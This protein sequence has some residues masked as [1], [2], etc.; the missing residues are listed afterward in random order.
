MPEIFLNKKKVKVIQYGEHCDQSI[1][2]MKFCSEMMY[3]LKTRIK[4]AS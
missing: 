1:N 2:I 4:K 3:L